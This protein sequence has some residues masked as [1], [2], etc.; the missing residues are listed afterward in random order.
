MSWGPAREA[1]PW[2]VE[3]DG[4]NAG[5]RLMTVR[6]LAATEGDLLQDGDL[7]I[8]GEQFTA[9]DSGGRPVPLW[10]WAIVG[11]L[12]VL[13]VEWAVYCHRIR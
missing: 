1:G 13:L 6:L 9:S 4:A 5:R 10:P 2:L 11:A 3:W 8:G 12:V 7:T